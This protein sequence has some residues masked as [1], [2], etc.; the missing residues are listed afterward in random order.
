MVHL[1]AQGRVVRVVVVM[2]I[3]ELVGSLG[4]TRV[5]AADPAAQGKL[6]VAD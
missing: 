5:T 6:R 2:G 4:L 1:P 3:A